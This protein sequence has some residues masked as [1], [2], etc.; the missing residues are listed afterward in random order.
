MSRENAKTRSHDK[1]K[2]DKTKFANTK[3]AFENKNSF[4]KSLRKINFESQNK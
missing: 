4:C 1:F 2:I 3:N